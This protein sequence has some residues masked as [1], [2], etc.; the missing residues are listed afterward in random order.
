MIRSLEYNSGLSL[1]ESQER[2][3]EVEA[4]FE[5][6][7]RN[8]SG[9]FSRFRHNMNEE[10]QKSLGECIGVLLPLAREEVLR[11]QKRDWMK[12]EPLSVKVMQLNLEI[13]EYLSRF[14][15]TGVRMFYSSEDILD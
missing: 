4:E 7:K 5:R 8:Y 13:A 6:V 14:N 15:N 2:Y 9:F 12:E 3:E 11:T 10:D 1:Q